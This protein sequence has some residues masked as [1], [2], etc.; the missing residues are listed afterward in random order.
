FIANQLNYWFK[1]PQ[2]ARE[3]F[4]E[5]L[6]HWDVADVL[7]VLAETHPGVEQVV[8]RAV[9]TLQPD[10]P[11]KRNSDSYPEGAPRVALL[12][13]I[14][15]VGGVQKVMGVQAGILAEAGHDVT[16]LSF[17]HSPSDVVQELPPGVE[18]RCIGPKNEVAVSVAGLIDA[19]L[20]RNIGVLLIHDNCNVVLP[21]VELVARLLRLRRA[22][23]IHSFAL[24]ALYDC[25]AV[26]AQLPEIASAYD[27][28]VTL[29]V[30]DHAWWEATGVRNIRALPNFV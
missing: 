12:G 8:R 6:R 10:F 15:G 7:K 28:T 14:A 22:L 21:C 3:A 11:E 1:L 27:V 2:P 4:D 24:R 9:K 30:A 13:N 19:V 23:F 5:L 26:I 16:V 20:E 29:S 17:D 25:H 18:I